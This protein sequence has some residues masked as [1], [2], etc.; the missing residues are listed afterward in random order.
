MKRA[1]KVAA[2]IAASVF[3]AAAAVYPHP[4]AGMGPGAGGAG[5]G[6]CAGAPGD[7]MGMGNSTAMM[8]RHLANLKAQLKITPAQEPAWQ[9]FATKAKEQADTMR[10]MRAKMLDATGPAPER[11]RQRTELM[12]QRVGNMETMTAALSDLYAAL[13]P[14][15]KAIAD[16][17]VGMMGGR[18]MGSKPAK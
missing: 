18:R 16:Q 5:M 3:F 9:A 14:E 11:M 17:H 13:T 12:K 1:H 15:Q 4:G 10:A 2:G 8:E 7:M 6:P